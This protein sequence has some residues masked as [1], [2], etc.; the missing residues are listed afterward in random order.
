MPH[1]TEFAA[2]HSAQFMVDSRETHE[3]DGMAVASKDRGLIGRQDDRT[4]LRR[5]VDL[6]SERGGA[7]LLQGEAGVGK[8]ALMNDVAAGAEQAGTRVLRA[9]GAEF[10]ADVSLAALHQLLQPIVRSADQLGGAQRRALHVALGLEDGPPADR[11]VLFNATLDLVVAAAATDP[12][13]LTV[14]DLPWVDRASA[15]I[16]GFVARR[17][18]GTRVGFLGSARTGEDGFFERAGIPAHEVQPLSTA[19]AVALLQDRFPQLTPRVRARLIAEA[20]GNPLAL[21]E[22]PVA[23]GDPL[24]AAGRRLPAVLPLTRRLTAVFATRIAELPSATRE[25]LL[26]AVLD[27]SGELRVLRSDQSDGGEL[28][29]LGPA[30]RSRLIKVDE[31]SRRLVFRHPLI[32]SAVI[33]LSTSDERRRAHQILAERR[34]GEPEHHVWHLSEAAVCPS[35][36]IANLLR[37][38]AETKFCRGDVAGGIANLLRAADLEPAG[39]GKSSLLAEAAYIGALVLG[40]LRDVP[41]LLEG[42]RESDPTSGGTLPDALASAYYL[43]NTDGGIDT[44]HGLLV[45]AIENLGN[46]CDAHDLMLIEGLFNLLEVCFFGGH[47]ELWEPFHAALERLDPNPPELL[48]VLRDTFGDPVRTALPTLERL[49]LAISGLRR[50]AQPQH[51]IRVGMAA[52]YLDRLTQ[53]RDP[54]LRLIDDGRDG[55][56]VTSAIQALFLLGIESYFA[57]RWDEVL[58]LTSEGLEHCA[59]N[60]YRLLSWPGVFLRA[61]VAA[62][63]GDGPTAIG[64]AAEMSGWAAPRHVGVVET[65]ACHTRALLALGCGEFEE[66]YR[67]AS[68]VSPPGAFASHAPH[69]LWLSMDLVEACVRTD[70]LAEANAHVEAA[71]MHR[72]EDLSPRLALTTRGASALCAPADSAQACFEG[73][74]ATPDANRWPFDHARIQLAYGVWLRRMKA[75]RTAR[76]YLAPAAE[77]FERLGARPWAARAQAELRAGGQNLEM[78]VSGVAALTPQQHE[79]ALLA[80]Q[81]FT[82]K[83]IGQQMFLSHRTVSTHLYQLFPKLGVTSRAALRDALSPT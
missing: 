13:L 33:E 28:S 50:E 75:N 52:A 79:I 71:S 8:T 7:L 43:L 45:G 16:L 81:G 55:G 36:E 49:D 58:D 6:A 57:G 64:L 18:N 4:T 63:R 21:L 82:N 34:K 37:G 35:G 65:Y 53:C 78:E 14:D 80:A 76:Q 9:V 56:K 22:L 11:L 61:L 3:V 38:V 73:A 17:L 25:L 31:D 10:E 66:A 54:L 72:L 24:S 68:L 42:V 70:R 23:L 59:A 30:E 77:T 2:S 20:G 29:R 19:H 74:L 1:L 41:R 39:R 40:D 67:Q 27:G 62:A 5:F 46:P 69:A 32:R 47:A 44:A 51:I 26:L 60:D 48:S 12:L 83:Q 15:V